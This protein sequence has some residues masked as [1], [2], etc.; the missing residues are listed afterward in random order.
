M[1]ILTDHAC[2]HVPGTS[3]AQ[4]MWLWVM[5]VL[6]SCRQHVY[7][8]LRTAPGKGCHPK[9]AT[10][11]VLCTT[12]ST[13][14]ALLLPALALL[15]LIRAQRNKHCCCGCC[16]CCCCCCCRMH[17]L[18]LVIWAGRL[19][20]VLDAQGVDTESASNRIAAFSV[21]RGSHNP[22]VTHIISLLW[23]LPSVTLLDDGLDHTT[24][25]LGGGGSAGS[26]RRFWWRW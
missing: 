6:P 12:N 24:I 25:T 23:C 15:L 20:S 21:V 26:T 18:L 9:L 5:H 7:Q 16:C 11:A 8:Q 22:R 1:T 10:T 14:A 17:W 3:A 4:L 19:Q 2:I 13:A